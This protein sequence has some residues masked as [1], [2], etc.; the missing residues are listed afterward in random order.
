MDAPLHRA[1]ALRAAGY[2]ADD[3]RRLRRTGGLVV[4]RRG[5]YVERTPDDA[6]AAHA[7]LLRAALAELAPDAVASHVSA[8][9]LHG[10]PMWGLPAGRAHVTF[11]RRTG[12]RVDDR[13]HVHTAPLHPDD[14]VLVDGVAATSLARTVV[15]VGR[16]HAFEPAVAVADAALRAGLDEWC[17]RAALRRA[18]GWPG[19]PGARRVAAFADGRAE[20]VGESRSRVAIARAGLPP[21]ELQVPVRHRDGIAFADFGWPQYR[22]LGEFDGKVKYGRL[23]RPGQTPADAVHAEKLREDLVRDEDW[24]MARWGWVDLD[25]F[26]PT[27]GRIRRRFRT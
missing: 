18:R 21:P 2:T 22:T 17:L 25:D 5:A 10:L 26:G 1:A 20:S 4:V 11:D 3:I 23:L 24:G 13:L 14:V 16:R 8:V 19:V 7:L 27:A 12:G 9:V 15:D 6:A